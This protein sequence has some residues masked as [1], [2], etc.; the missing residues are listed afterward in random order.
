MTHLLN[1]DAVGVEVP[2]QHS[3]GS[4]GLDARRRGTV[5]G[6][7]GGRRSEAN[8]RRED[9]SDKLMRE[10]DGDGRGNEALSVLLDLVSPRGVLSGE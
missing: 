3:R 10:L 8:A 9:L 6:G 2:D 4:K 1:K 7:R 5:V